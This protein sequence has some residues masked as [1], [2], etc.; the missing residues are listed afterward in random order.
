MST[1]RDILMVYPLTQINVN[2][3]GG[4]TG[5]ILNLA[6]G[7]QIT[8]TQPWETDQPEYS[9]ERVA[10]GCSAADGEEDFDF[11]GEDDLSVADAILWIQKQMLR[12]G[13]V[14][15]RLQL[16]ESVKDDRSK[17]LALQ[18]EWIGHDDACD[19]DTAQTIADLL[20][21]YVRVEEDEAAR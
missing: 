8:I 6:D 7:R 3:G 17:L 15:V 4:C 18:K 21:G 9:D 11:E 14:F 5:W 20:R 12:A 16:V 2:T 13:R 10:V 1:A 19:D